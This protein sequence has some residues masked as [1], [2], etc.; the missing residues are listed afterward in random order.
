MLQQSISA[1][2][3]LISVRPS[4]GALYFTNA[5]FSEVLNV[6]GNKLLTMTKNNLNLFKPFRSNTKKREI[7]IR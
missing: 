4:N 5:S 2:N 3:F 6:P 1:L 7:S